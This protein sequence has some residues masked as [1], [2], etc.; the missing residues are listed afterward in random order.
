MTQTMNTLT[1]D[2]N[3][4]SRII[5]NDKRLLESVEYHIG[6]Y[7]ERQAILYLYDYFSSNSDVD[8]DEVDWHVIVD[9]YAHYQCKNCG[10]RLMVCE[11]D[12]EHPQG[13]LWSH[14]FVTDCDDPDLV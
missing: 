2:T 8:V 5:D 14:L 13:I 10:G 3:E 11:R 12:D 7:E 1:W 4:V 9:L 6:A